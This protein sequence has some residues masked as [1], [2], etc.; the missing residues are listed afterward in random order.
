MDTD[1]AVLAKIPDAIP[2]RGHPHLYGD[3]LIQALLGVKTDY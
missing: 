1:A 3:M 2:M